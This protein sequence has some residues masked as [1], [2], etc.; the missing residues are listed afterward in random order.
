MVT[1]PPSTKEDVKVVIPRA[2]IVAGDYETEKSA[3]QNAAPAHWH[4]VE[5]QPEYGQNGFK[6]LAGAC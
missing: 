1:Q 6:F 2:V 4:G 3:S 5:M